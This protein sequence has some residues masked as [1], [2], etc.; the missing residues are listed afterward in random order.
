MYDDKVD[1]RQ[2]DVAKIKE[3]YSAAED[4]LQRV[5]WLLKH[6]SA[7]KFGWARDHRSAVT[8]LRATLRILRD[9]VPLYDGSGL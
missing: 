3:A 8:G 6:T 5:S 7:G 1:K 9:D 4:S 2:V